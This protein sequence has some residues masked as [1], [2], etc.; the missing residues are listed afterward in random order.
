MLDCFVWVGDQ[1]ICAANTLFNGI[2]FLRCLERDL[3]L[4]DE[5]FL[6]PF[7]VFLFDE[8]LDEPLP[9]SPRL[10]R[11]VDCDLLETFDFDA[12]V[13]LFFRSD[14]FFVGEAP[15]GP[16]FFK[17]FEVEFVFLA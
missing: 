14:D 15:R 10:F 4:V 5:V 6:P 3:P 1:S 13:V 11:F 9:L 12:F 2:Y 8:S 17:F 7:G 16:P